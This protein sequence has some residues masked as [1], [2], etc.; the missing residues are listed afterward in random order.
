[1]ARPDR[2][3]KAPASVRP[4]QCSGEPG[5]RWVW[6]GSPDQGWA[7]LHMR[8]ARRRGLGERAGLRGFAEAV[9]GPRDRPTSSW[10]RTLGQQRGASIIHVTADGA[11]WIT[12]VVAERCGNAVTCADPFHSLRRRQRSNV[13]SPHDPPLP[14]RSPRAYGIRASERPALRPW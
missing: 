14:S 5:V 9:S 3:A 2:V 13:L 8:A 6:C 12:T 7:A 11:D 10:P 1:M 4:G